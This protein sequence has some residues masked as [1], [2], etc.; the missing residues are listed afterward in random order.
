MKKVIG[1]L[2]SN[3]DL[4]RAVSLPNHAESYTV[5]SHGYVMDTIQ[6]EL[7]KNNLEVERELYYSSY[8]GEV[9]MGTVHIK[10]KKDEDMGMVFT[11]WNSYNK[12]VKFG[13]AIGGFIEE[14]RT[15]FIG[16]EGMS[17][18]RKH[19]GTSNLEAKNVV[20]QLIAQADHYFDK[21]IA[22]KE[23]MKA[24]PLALDTF[25]C[26]MGAIYFELDLITP[27][28][29]SAVKNEFKKPIHEYKHKDTLWGLYQLLMF[30]ISKMDLRKWAKNQQKI[31]HTIINEYLISNDDSKPFVDTLID[32]MKE[33]PVAD[34]ITIPNAEI[35]GGFFDAI[36]KKE[37]TELVQFTDPAGDT[38]ELPMIKESE[39][40]AV[41]TQM[42]QEI[43][44][45][46][47]NAPDMDVS[48]VDMSKVTWVDAP[49]VKLTDVLPQARIDTYIEKG[50]IEEEKI[51]E[52][53]DSTVNV[54]FLSKEEVL[55]KYPDFITEKQVD[56]L[57]A[58]GKEMAAH[59]ETDEEYHKRVAT[60]E[61]EPEELSMTDVLDMSPLPVEIIPPSPVDNKEIF[62]NRMINEEK[63][64]EHLVN[65]F[66]EEHYAPLFSVDEN[67]GFFYAWHKPAAKVETIIET[68][69]ETV[70]EVPVKA[71]DIEDDLLETVDELAIT[72]PKGFDWLNNDDIEGTPTMETNLLEIPESVS[73][74]DQSIRTKM[75]KLYGEVKP[76]HYIEINNYCFVTL[77]DTKEMFYIQ[78]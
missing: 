67:A 6:E 59:I 70:I 8:D 13:C 17:W 30:G 19:T 50:F 9:A 21:L 7:D 71:T 51:K 14:N 57:L 44:D 3:K 46:L 72:L 42:P 41:V 26:I 63:Q 10:S 25:G 22:E 31:H 16:S 29:A 39:I 48:K 34:G 33:S 12:S 27:N 35:S 40:P 52:L 55:E 24:M 74:L 37:E 66:M 15:M 32:A 18:V 20:E 49:E 69:A 68:V 28:Q 47:M 1:T 60:I 76:F 75:K 5:I 62:I 64:S 4:L 36:D 11:W 23:K 38:F 65:Y 77:D 56:D 45:A 53:P 73:L 43:M 58:Q 2:Q 61:G 54:E 78:N